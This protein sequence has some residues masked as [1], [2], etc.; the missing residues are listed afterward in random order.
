VAAAFAQPPASIVEVAERYGRLFA[1]VDRRWL[2]RQAEAKRRGEA[3]PSA[4][5]DPDDEAL[6][7]VLHGPGSPC[8]VPDEGIVSTES[9]LR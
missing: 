8:R 2:E 5:P 4:L 3:A 1:E 9:F 7:L 6:R